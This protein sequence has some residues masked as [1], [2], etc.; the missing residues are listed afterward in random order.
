[1]NNKRKVNK[2]RHYSFDVKKRGPDF[3]GVYRPQRAFFAKTLWKISSPIA[4]IGGAG[5]YDGIFVTSILAVLLG[6]LM[7]KR[8]RCAP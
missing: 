3:M 5:T 2:S 6:S 8:K 7:T 4:S 1:M